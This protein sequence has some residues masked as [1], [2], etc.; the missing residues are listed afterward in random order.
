M[1][2]KKRVLVV[3]DDVE[4]I[5]VMK[6]YF[7]RAGFEADVADSGYKALKAYE[8][9]RPDVVILDIHMP[10]MDGFRVC[11]KIRNEK[12]DKNT[13]IIAITGYSRSD[14]R[15]KILDVGANMLLDKPVDMTRLLKSVKQM[16]SVVS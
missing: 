4:L 14:K 6:I 8:E 13:P 12:A 1:A 5:K 2:E 9:K 10:K 15:K 11:E 16:T 3:D 7:N